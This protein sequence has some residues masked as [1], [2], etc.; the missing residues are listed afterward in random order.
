MEEN[1]SVKKEKRVKFDLDVKSTT[2]EKDRNKSITFNIDNSISEHSN[3]KKIKKK[4]KK[5]RSEQ[6]KNKIFEKKNIRESY[7]KENVKEFKNNPKENKKINDKLFNLKKDII[8]NKFEK[9]NRN[10]NEFIINIDTSSLT[11]VERTIIK[12]GAFKDKVNLLTLLALN[13]NDNDYLSILLD[14]YYSFRY[15]NRYVVLKN[16]TDL[17]KE[18]FILNSGNKIKIKRIFEEETKG[19]FIKEKTVNLIEDIL[20]ND[21]LIN[22]LLYIYI[23]K[24]GDKKEISSKVFES[25]KYIGRKNMKKISYELIL[26]YEK[27]DSLRGKINAVKFLVE[28]C[29]EQNYTDFYSDS[30]NEIILKND[31]Q[32]EKLFYYLL[33]GMKDAKVSNISY[34]KLKILLKREKLVLPT[35]YLIKNN[36]NDKLFKILSSVLTQSLDIDSKDLL[37]FIY[38]SVDIQRNEVI[39]LLCSSPKIKDIK[40]LTGVIMLAKAFEVDLSS[41]KSLLE[42]HYHPMVRNMIKNNFNQIFDPFDE[43]ELKKAVYQSFRYWD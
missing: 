16:I 22:D 30:F 40:F 43:T 24:L 6:N 14:N 11:D 9:K 10:K 7:N 32:Q 31:T 12:D 42:Y 20:K 19:N 39:C 23:N 3:S 37:N 18:G 33:Q 27:C 29:R 36:F 21:C 4:N 13:N 35:L 15:D 28:N 17:I 26:F 1:I 5:I 41:I 38:E 2:I 34:D 8:L 25:L